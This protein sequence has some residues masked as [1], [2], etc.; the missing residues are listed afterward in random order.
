MDGCACASSSS[1]NMPRVYRAMIFVS[2]LM[3]SSDGAPAET[4]VVVDILLVGIPD[5][6]ACLWNSVESARVH[7]MMTTTPIGR[8][9]RASRGQQ[10][11]I[12]LSPE[13]AD[14][15]GIHHIDADDENNMHFGADAD[16]NLILARW[17]P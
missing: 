1:S 8:A 14:D 13:S 5:T 3:M 16:N 2:T 11:G 6:A 7:I 17:R 10:T 12:T 4:A 9:H 15:N